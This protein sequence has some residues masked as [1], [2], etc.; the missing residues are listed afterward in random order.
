MADKPT[1]PRKRK[2]KLG[3][4][5]ARPERRRVEIDLMLEILEMFRASPE[6]AIA[7]GADPE[8]AGLIERARLS[9]DVL[10]DVCNCSRMNIWLWEQSGL[11]KM[12]KAGERRKL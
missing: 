7:A 4:K 9:I 11:N 5:Q 3:T 2:V 10:A 8:L 1:N 6:E 12:R